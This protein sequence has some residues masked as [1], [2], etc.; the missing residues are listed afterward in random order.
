VLGKRGIPK[1][2]NESRLDSRDSIPHDMQLLSSGLGHKARR[3]AEHTKAV[4]SSGECRELQREQRN[5]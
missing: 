2:W 5:E 3:W 4:I 1:V